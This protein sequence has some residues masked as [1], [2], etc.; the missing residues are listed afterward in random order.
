MPRSRKAKKISRVS[1]K[2]RKPLK[3][4]TRA[5]KALT[6][7]TP[8]SR[9]KIV[10]EPVPLQP[11]K[12]AVEAQPVSPAPFYQPPRAW[13]SAWPS[14]ELPENYGDNLIYALV[15]DPYWIYVYWEIQRD[16]QE[17]TLGQVGGNW[18]QV[19]SILRVYD[20]TENRGFP[21]FYDITLHGLANN[22][23]IEAQPNRTYAIEIG[24]LHE[25]G[26]YAALARSNEVTTPRSGMSEV[27]DEEWMSI[28]FDK[29]YALSGGFGIGKSSL[30]LK[31]LM[32]QRLWQAISS[33]SG[34]GASPVKIKAKGFWFTVDCELILYGATEPDAKVTVQG[35]P[36]ELRPDGTFTLRFALPDGKLV[37]DAKA[38]SADRSEE[39]N[40]R[41]TVTR[42][43]Q[44][45]ASR[46]KSK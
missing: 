26:R 17:R 21:S 24:L 19:K 6:P 38:L 41:P 29:M 12:Y 33:G 34:M 43:T 7:P 10:R 13:E 32:E 40:I 4:K 39:I 36:V 5:R 8:P 22:W 16:H 14:G 37:L 27:I 28:D 9:S 15:R 31:Q 23:Y 42:K 18:N 2:K 45:P 46:S 3:R 44:Q 30:E 35:K 11:V 1:A 20:L 25:D